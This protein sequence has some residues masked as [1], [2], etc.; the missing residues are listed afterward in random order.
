MK[1]AKTIILLLIVLVLIS[2]VAGYVAGFYVYKEYKTKTEHLERQTQNKFGTLEKNLKELYVALENTV[3]KNKAEVQGILSELEAIREDIE[4][5]NR[6][7]RVIVAELK[8]EIDNL[9][10][11]KLTRMVEKLQS[12]I[13]SFKIKIQDLE[14]KDEIKEVDLGKIS[15]EK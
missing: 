1:N 9:K 14:L 3:D 13:D 6:G 11:D 2:I 4:K 12:E 5:W 10:I 7:Y 8:G 15:V